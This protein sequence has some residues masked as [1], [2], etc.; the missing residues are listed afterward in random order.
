MDIRQVSDDLCANIQRSLELV[1]ALSEISKD[2]ETFVKNG[3]IEGLR[4]V[5]EKE[6]DMLAEL[7]RVEKDRKRKADDLSQA[8]GLFNN[9]AP[10]K[11]IIDNIPDQKIRDRLA[12]LRISLLDAITGLAARNEMLSELIGMRMQYTDYMLNLLYTPQKKNHG[13]DVMGGRK[14][15]A[16]RFNMI[17]INI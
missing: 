12:G 16:G 17:D 11:D 2:K 1:N 3:D 8:I 10:L 6:E 9:D 14:D 13:Y 4:A 7:G 5:T 15:E